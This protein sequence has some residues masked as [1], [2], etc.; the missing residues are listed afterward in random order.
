MYDVCF[1]EA[2][3]AARREHKAGISKTNSKADARREG[4]RERERRL[5]DERYRSASVTSFFKY[6]FVT[7]CYIELICVDINRGCGFVDY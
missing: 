7:Y 3:E 4:R 1:R 2:V 5:R 6:L